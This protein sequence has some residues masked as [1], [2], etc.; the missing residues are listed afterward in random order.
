MN[1][2][3]NARLTFARRLEMVQDITERGLTPCAGGG[4]ARRE[5]ADG[6]QVAGP[7]PGRR[8][9]G[10]GRRVVAA[11]CSPRAIEPAK[12]LADRRVAPPA[13]DAGAHR[14]SLGVSEEHRQPGAGPRRPVPAERSGA[15]RAGAC[16]TSMSPLAICC[17][18][19]PR[20]SVASSG[21]A[22]GSP[23]TGATRSTA[24]AGSCCSWPSTTTRASPSPTCTRTSAD[25]QRRAVPARRRGLLRSPG[26]AACDAC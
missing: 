20:S 24:P 14:R 25:A 8:R 19:T 2:H 11:G 1:T 23:A 6:A 22:T 18:S 17:T 7:L 13:P 16:A 3:K 12:A 26:R 4:G 10:P 15:R 9:G 21:P 5:R